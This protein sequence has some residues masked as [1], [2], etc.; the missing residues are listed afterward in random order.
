MSSDFSHQ[1]SNATSPAASMS[2]AAQRAV[3]PSDDGRSSNAS[4]APSSQD[5]YY[6]NE[7]VAAQELLDSA[8]EPKPLPA[9]ALFKAYDAVLPT[10]GIDPDSDHHLSTF[11]FRVGGER[12]DGSLL[13]KF[14]AILS[15]MG[16]V[17]EFGDNTT[18]SPRTS[19][20]TS[21]AAYKTAMPRL[22]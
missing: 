20:S 14:Q 11:V 6:S 8:P 1:G 3:S 4:R 18:A 12:G 10:Y 19:A 2:P 7:V 16:I 21:P 9:A 5:P 15:R 17:L 22:D 13:D